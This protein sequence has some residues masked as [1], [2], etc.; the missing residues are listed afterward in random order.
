MINTRDISFIVCILQILPCIACFDWELPECDGLD[1]CSL[2]VIENP[3][4]G[5][6]D[7]NLTDADGSATQSPE[8]GTE[9][10]TATEV[11][12][13]PDLDSGLT[14]DP[15]DV[16]GTQP[17]LDSG[18]AQG[19]DDVSVAFE[20]G[21]QPD[22]DS[23]LTQGPG[24]A[25]ADTCSQLFGVSCERFSQ[26][27]IKASNTGG[28]DS[29]GTAVS[30]DGDTL[31]VGAMGEASS[32]QGVGADQQNDSAENSGAVY[33]F[34]R[35]NGLW[36]QQAY[37]K[38]SNAEANDQFGFSVSVDGDILA[39]GA[40]GERSSAQG[41]N[42]DESDNTADGSGAV[43][44]FVRINNQWVQQ[45]YLKASNTGTFDEFGYSVSVSGTSI[46]VGAIG[47]ASSAR[48]VE[49]DQQNNTLQGVGAVYVFTLNNSVW[50]QEAYIK[51]SNAG[52]QT[53]LAFFGSSISFD[54]DT[55]AVAAAGE[56]SSQAGINGSGQFDSSAPYSGAVY[57][58]TR[59]N[60]VW[61]QEAHI[62]AS[63]PEGRDNTRPGDFG[64]HFGST[65]SLDGDTLAVAAFGEDSSAAGVGN[66]QLDNA[67]AE[68]GAVYVFTR[69]NTQWS[70]Q[71]YIKASNT[72]AADEFGSP[73]LEFGRGVAVSGDLLAV[74]A[75]GEASNGI[76]LS[77]DQNNNDAPYS[78][79][80]YLFSRGSDN[81]WT[82]S[83]YIKSSNSNSE[84]AFGFAV[85]LQGNTLVVGASGED[86]SAVGV[87]GNQNDNF[88]PSSGAVYVR[89]VAP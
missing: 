8:V 41:I 67:A 63:N 23:G 69:T 76:N 50:R 37:L 75:I 89:Q 73:S 26:G 43:Y 86:S 58:F 45:A 7:A 66:D 78:G 24:D 18:L 88:L 54:G 38:A 59:A 16:S 87:G 61:S 53:S 34:T 49:A 20:V 79:A 70:Q 47:E 14:Q 74:G 13:Q 17:D 21:T 72:N 68:S 52:D 36:S 65:V 84:D 83:A 9:T 6:V 12:T 71:A 5:T 4:A 33:V 35:T 10:G 42:Q 48:G 64:D 27:Y 29:F 39:V 22:L 25:G 55:L 3:D 32:S 62:K 80:V 19:P 30:I 77:A 15:D 40:R 81:Q 82:Q 44:V 85:D 2:P 60:G 46:A 57:V 28:R 51:A 31:V 11:G 1:T 56:A